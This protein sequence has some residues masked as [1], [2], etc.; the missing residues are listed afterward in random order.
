MSN[1]LLQANTVTSRPPLNIFEASR[2]LLQGNGWVTLAEVPQY[3]IPGN[4]PNPAKTVNAV[5]IM[6]G[7]TITNITNDTIKASARIVGPAGEIYPVLTES[8][9][10]PNDFL[11]ISFDRQVMMTWE[12]LQVSI[13]SNTTANTHACAHFSYIINQREEFNLIESNPRI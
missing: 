4:G 8:V 3:Y 1:F 10:P 7:L 2:E 5:A 13:P 9:I 12:K 6:T 11:I